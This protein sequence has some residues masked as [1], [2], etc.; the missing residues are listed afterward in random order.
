MEL[1]WFECFVFF[2][3]I[4]AWQYLSCYKF[5][6]GLGKKKHASLTRHYETKKRLR[7]RRNEQVEKIEKLNIPPS[8]KL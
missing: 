3:Q 2:K 5:A 4:A 6:A 7:M 8:D 1:R